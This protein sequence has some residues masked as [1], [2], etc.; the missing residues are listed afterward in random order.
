MQGSSS[1]LPEGGHFTMGIPK[2]SGIVQVLRQRGG[3]EEGVVDGETATTLTDPAYTKVKD[4]M[5]LERINSFGDN[6]EGSESG[7]SKSRVKRSKMLGLTRVHLG[8]KYAW[9]YPD[10]PW[11]RKDI[12]RS[13]SKFLRVIA[14]NH[15]HS[16]LRCSTNLPCA[17]QGDQL[18]EYTKTGTGGA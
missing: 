5:A 12:H 15:C 4:F 9:F 14:H 16:Q 18:D 2:R 8:S 1:L 10:P 13:G 3:M 11:G 6:V 17:L 7:N